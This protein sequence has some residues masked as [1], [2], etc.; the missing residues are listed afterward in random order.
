MKTEED[1]Y[2]PKKILMPLTGNT[3]IDF[4]KSLRDLGLD[5][6]RT[7]DLV[8]TIEDQFGVEFDDEDLSSESL[9]SPEKILELLERKLR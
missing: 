6:L 8:L 3:E 2:K 5:S 9:K 7:M 4:T 1:K